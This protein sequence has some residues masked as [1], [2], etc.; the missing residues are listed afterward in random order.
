MKRFTTSLIALAAGA[1]T[2]LG[3]HPAQAH[4]SAA[5]GVLG[6]LTHPL[7]GLDH[8]FMLMAVGAAASFFSARLLL[9][10]AV[11]AIA[12]AAAGAWGLHVPAAE[13]WAALAVAALGGFTLVATRA[14]TPALASLRHNGLDSLI[15]LVVAGGAAIHALL[16]GQ[17]APADGSALLWWSGAL[18]SSVLVCGGAYRVFR[19]LPVAF[20]KAG[21]V[22]FFAVGGALALAP[23]ALLVGGAGG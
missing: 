5:S 23:L 19:S 4:G 18:I 12:G 11:G 21:A 2:L 6:G 16:H 15:G 9:W 10:A 3:S 22:V 13:V 20:T 7:F 17:E 8:L 14:A 1:A